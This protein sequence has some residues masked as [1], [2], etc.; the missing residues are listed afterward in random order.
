MTITVRDPDYVNL[1]QLYRGRLANL[2]E[3]PEHLT[4]LRHR[5][6]VLGTCINIEL[7]YR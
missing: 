3:L 1:S 7:R 6:N 5:H 2:T 4:R